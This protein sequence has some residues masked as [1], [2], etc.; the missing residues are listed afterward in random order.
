MI[1]GESKV[2][3][4]RIGSNLNKVEYKFLSYFLVNLSCKVVI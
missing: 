2:W 1:R 3:H 4:T